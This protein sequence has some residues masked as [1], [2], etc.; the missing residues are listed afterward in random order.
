MS[1]NPQ[2]PQINS[3]KLRVGR[4]I[5]GA[6]ITIGSVLIFLTGI[7]VLRYLFPV[8]IVVGCGV[9]LL[10]HFIRYKN[11]GAPWLLSATQKETGTLAKPKGNGNLERYTKVSWTPPPVDLS[12]ATR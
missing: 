5:A 9:A 8:A 6:I 11:P 4:G 2:S 12:L 3:A 1:D 10:L 7:P